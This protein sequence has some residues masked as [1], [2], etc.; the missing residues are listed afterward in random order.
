MDD[1]TAI[2]ING[3]QFWLYGAID[4]DIIDY[5]YETIRIVWD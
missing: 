2:G 1:E 3:G 4:T 5:W